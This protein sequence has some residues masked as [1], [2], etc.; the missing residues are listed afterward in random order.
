VAAFRAHSQQLLHSGTAVAEQGDRRIAVGGSSMAPGLVIVAGA[1]EVAVHGSPARQPAILGAASAKLFARRTTSYGQAA[2]RRLYHGRMSAA[3]WVC[4]AITAVSAL[5]SLGYS[6]AALTGSDTPGRTNSMYAT[7][8]SLALAVAAVTVL[9]V[10]SDSFL[11]AIALAMVV[12]Q[13]GDAFIGVQIHDRLKT[14]GPA[15]TAL[16]N[17][18]ALI[19]L[20]QQ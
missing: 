16:M 7:A 17:A 3:F 8:R 13:A 1:L 9:F 20:L 2:G 11:E 5:V 15:L 12:V 19:W 18:I 14:I 4:A 6:I 10:R